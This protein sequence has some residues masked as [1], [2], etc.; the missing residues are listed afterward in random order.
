MVEKH[1]AVVV[2][3]VVH[4]AHFEKSLRHESV[5][6]AEKRQVLDLPEV[7]LLATEHQAEVKACPVCHK[8]TR[9][10]FPIDVTQAVQYGMRLKSQMTY[11]H[12]YQLLARTDL[13]G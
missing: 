13:Y 5:S 8:L 11:F 9:A 1:D 6:G 3:E 10:A 2:Y 12:E 4:C 7:R